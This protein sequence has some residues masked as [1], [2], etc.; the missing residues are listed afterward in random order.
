MPILLTV[1]SSTQ[2]S[3]NMQRIQLSG[4]ELERYPTHCAGGYI[5][6]LF[7]HN[8]GTDLTGYSPENRPLMRT[9]T[10][11]SFDSA[12]LTMDVDFVRHECNDDKSGFAAKWAMNAKPGDTIHVGG[13]GTIKSHNLEADWFMMV[14]DMTALPAL[15]AKVKELPSDAKGY[16]VIKVIEEAD[17]VEIEAPEGLDVHWITGND[18]LSDKVKSLTWLEGEVSVWSASEFDDMRALRQYFRN[19]KNVDRDNIYI[20]S[21]W[22]QGVTEDGHKVIKQ[23]DAI[24][25]ESRA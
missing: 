15:S 12:A 14:A 8:G 25:Q 4:D 7:N 19:D 3:A 17:I 13:P 22:K 21:Y 5:K 18:S 24:E 23:E 10:I 16:A 6:L 11:R 20:S 2:I 1:N 9:Y